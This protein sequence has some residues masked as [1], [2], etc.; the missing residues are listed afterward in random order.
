MNVLI[1]RSNIANIKL[2]IVSFYYCFGFYGFQFNVSFTD[3]VN[4]LL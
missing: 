2:F 1:T 4:T 3:S